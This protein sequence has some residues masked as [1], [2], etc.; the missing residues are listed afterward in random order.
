[1]KRT[2]GNGC[3]LQATGHGTIV[4][5][6]ASTSGKTSRMELHEV[7]RVPVQL[8]QCVK[9]SGNWTGG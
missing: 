8:A 1:M 7:L 2:L 4:S 5:E 9:G 6:I 3:A